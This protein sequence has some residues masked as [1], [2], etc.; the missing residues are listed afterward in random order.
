M[1]LTKAL[2]LPKA[3]LR[4][5]GLWLCLPFQPQLQAKPCHHQNNILHRVKRRWNS[6]PRGSTPN[7]HDPGTSSS[8]PALAA[9]N[10]AH[11]DHVYSSK[12]Q[13]GQVCG[14]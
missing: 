11:F 13:K 1:V 10:A 4:L 14:V 9:L 7:Y 5:L 3:A 2:F 12:L 6:F 8:V